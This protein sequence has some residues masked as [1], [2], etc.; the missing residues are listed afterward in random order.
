[1]DRNINRSRKLGDSLAIKYGIEVDYITTDLSDFNSVREAE[2][3]GL[4]VG[5]ETD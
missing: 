4:I 2:K 5:Y 1:M 3:G